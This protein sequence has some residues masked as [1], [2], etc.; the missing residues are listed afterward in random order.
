MFV[1]NKVEGLPLNGEKTPMVEAMERV[2][3]G[4]EPEQTAPVVGQLTINGISFGPKVKSNTGFDVEVIAA[5][6]EGDRLTYVWE[7]LKEATVTA[8]GGA[9]EPR[10]DRVGK[11]RTTE[12]GN[13]RISIDTPGYYRLYVYVLD[14]TGY[15]S[16]ANIPFAVIE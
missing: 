2:W 10:P 7:V 16:T 6:K 3:T 1:E 15:V 4:T 5:D 14:H 9:Y 8:T 13:V 12:T 11:V